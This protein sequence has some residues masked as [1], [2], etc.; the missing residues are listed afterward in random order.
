MGLRLA[1]LLLLSGCATTQIEYVPFE[2]RVPI[3]VPCAVEPAPEPQWATEGL[4]KSDTLDDK[5]KA[6]LAE[7]VQRQGYEAKLK[8]A[9]EGCR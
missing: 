4:K 3:P 7:R 8:A 9:V 1:A 2:V 6:L 5:A